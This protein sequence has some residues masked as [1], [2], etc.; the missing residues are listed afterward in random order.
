MPE[1]ST[2]TVIVVDDPL[3]PACPKCEARAQRWLAGRLRNR[4]A[5]RQAAAFGRAIS[6]QGDGYGWLALCQAA[7]WRPED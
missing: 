3:P 4:L 6:Y 1:W 5:I 7:G 2:T